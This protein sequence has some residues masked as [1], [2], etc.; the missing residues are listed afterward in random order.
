MIYVVKLILTLKAHVI[1][2]SSESV[3]QERVEVG[4]WVVV[5]TAYI[6]TSDF[7][8]FQPEPQE[9]HHSHPTHT[10]CSFSY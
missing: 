4:G 1:T 7:P 10:L 6:L 8:P 9:R 2:S 5:G 3:Y